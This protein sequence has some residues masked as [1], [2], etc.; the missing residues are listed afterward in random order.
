[1]PGRRHGVELAKRTAPWLLAAVLA[2]V[3]VTAVGSAGAASRKVSAVSVERLGYY[4]LVD[5]EQ[6]VNNKDDRARG[7]GTNPFGT[8]QGAGIATTNEKAKGPLPGD[9]GLYELKLYPDPQLKK[10]GP[11]ANFV[12]QYQFAKI[13]GCDVSVQLDD[14]TIVGTTDF[15]ALDNKQFS[16]IVTGGTG[17]YVNARGSI[18]FTN[19]S[20]V[21][22]T[23][24]TGKLKVTHNVPV[25]LLEPMHLSFAL[26]SSS[27]VTGKQTIYSVAKTEQFID[28]SDDE[29]RGW[30]TNPFAMRDRAEEAL[31]NNGVSPLPGDESLFSLALYS[32]S[33]Q[34]VSAGNATLTC[35]YSF[36]RT[37]F[38]DV[39]YQLK[40]GT[41]L[42]VGP[43]GFD[44]KTFSLA[45]V[46]G[47]G[48]YEHATGDLTSSQGP[49]NTERVDLSLG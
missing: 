27:A 16:V 31:E 44:G 35:E 14:G 5:K 13:G 19:A 37:A 46:G 33:N 15:Q 45:I 22:G 25:V 21:V 49:D 17:R 1:M 23:G 7:E 47:S 29:R 28:N 6:F 42:A 38:C 4:A 2:L 11:T 10:P 12:C 39:S 43:I 9:E 34:K 8:A 18:D 26:H 48:K 32:G 40:D 41:L 3:A 20:S 30:I 24:V 36:S